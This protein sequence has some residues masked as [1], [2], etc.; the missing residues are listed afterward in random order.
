VKIPS[1]EDVAEKLGSTKV[2]SFRHEANKRG[3]PCGHLHQRFIID[4]EHGTVQCAECEEPVSAFH[5]LCATARSEGLFRRQMHSLKAERD[6]L[7][8]WVPLLRAVR[9]LHS[10]WL[11]KAMVPCCPHC[12]RGV[13]AL[14]LNQ[15]AISAEMD[16]AQRRRAERERKGKLR[17]K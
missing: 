8:A 7:R 9:Y 11:G 12:G 1:E 6:E 2:L 10:M 14:E 3:R 5:A 4:Q 15:S 13:T 17:G 16:M